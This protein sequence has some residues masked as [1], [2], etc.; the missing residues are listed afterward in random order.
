MIKSVQDP[1]QAA[2]IDEPSAALGLSVRD[3]RENEEESMLSAAGYTLIVPAGT[4][5]PQHALEP[6]VIND[7]TDLG[8]AV[9]DL[10]PVMSFTN[11]RI[12][13][14]AIEFAKLFRLRPLVLTG[15]PEANYDGPFTSVTAPLKRY[16]WAD[17]LDDQ[18]KRQTG[19]LLEALQ[20]AP[21]DVDPGDM[22]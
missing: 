13:A 17:F 12:L 5:L 18:Q 16:N 6:R 19:K 21:D 22:E 4:V 11:N 2:T 3:D 8:V 1:F 10:A 9:R 20:K 7:L 15:V 14:L